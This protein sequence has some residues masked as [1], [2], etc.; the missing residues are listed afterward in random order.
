[1]ALDPT[2]IKELQEKLQAEKDRLES[3]LSKF[4]RKTSSPGEYE[5]RMQ[6][7]G[8]TMEENATEVEEYVD[9]LAVETNLEQ[10]LRDILDALEK[11]ERGTYGICEKTGKDI[12]IERLRAYPAARTAL[13]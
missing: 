6:N 5:T 2:I 11:I 7:I 13:N 9:N 1:M 4:A 12:S 3:A 10:E 8:D